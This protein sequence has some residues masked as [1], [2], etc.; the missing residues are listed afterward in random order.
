[1]SEPIH[2]VLCVDDE[3]E[4]VE[5]LRRTLRN[6]GYRF[7]GTT[8]PHEALALVEAGGVDLLVADID[9]PG[10]TGL[11][12]VA[13]VRRSRPHVVRMLL[14][15][16]A[17]LQS[18]LHAINEGEVHRYLTKPWQKQHL[19]DTIQEA[20]A[21]LDELRQQAAANQQAHRRDVLLAELERAHPGIRHVALADGVYELDVDRLATVLVALRETGLADMCRPPSPRPTIS[22]EAPTEAFG[23]D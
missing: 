23:K 1:M 20:L 17:S 13:R 19:R 4:I 3:P 15:G 22:G 7:V 16:D 14:T 10:M 18:A 12:L 2:T 8:S 6:E 11:E 21:R 5:T 9:M